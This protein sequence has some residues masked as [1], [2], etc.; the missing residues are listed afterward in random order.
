LGQWSDRLDAYMAEKGLSKRQLSAELAVPYSTVQKWWH[1]QPSRE[2]ITTIRRFLK[3]DAAAT[4]SIFDDK[5]APSPPSV[6]NVQEDSVS[7]RKE[8]NPPLTEQEAERLLS[9]HEIVRDPV[10]HDIWIT[11][12]ERVM[13]DAPAFQR[14]RSLNQLG[15]T[16]LVYPGA[17]HNRFLHS[18][19]TLHCAEQ[20][21]QIVNRN[22]R[23]Y[24]QPSLLD[25]GPYPHLLIRC[26]ALLH[27][28]AHMPFGHTLENEGNLAKGEWHDQGRAKLWLGDDSEW[29]IAGKVREFLR[30]SGIGASKADRVVQD[31]RRY[32]LPG[33][34]DEHP[35]FPV[36]D[37]PSDLDYPFVVD[38]VGNTLCADLL[39]Y[40][41]RDMYF[42]GLRE[43]SGDRVVQ[44]LAIV[45]VVRKPNG[46]GAEEEFQPSEKPDTGK[47]RVVLLAYRFEREHFASGNLK[48][49]PKAEILSEAIDLLRRRFALAEKVYFHRTKI[50]ASAMLISAVGSASTPLTALHTAS[51]ME[52]LAAL[53][54]DSE[55][56]ARH[57][58]A[59]YEARRLYKPVYRLNYREAREEDRQSIRLWQVMYPRYRD[60]K[61]RREREIELESIR[62]IPPGSIAVYCPDNTMNLKQF[63]MLVQSHP[64]ADVKYLKNILDPN[65]KE[66]MET[67]NAR[68]TQLWKLQVFVDPDAVDVSLVANDAVRD[69]SALCESVMGFPNEVPELQRK[70]RHL[71]DQV[72][73]I[74]VREWEGDDR[75]AVPYQVFK[76]LVAA[77]Y[78]G[79][80][81][82]L[83]DS[84]RKRLKAL[85]Q[86]RTS[87]ATDEKA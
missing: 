51:D 39:D 69:L 83:I 53:A 19:G 12:M 23:V 65:R 60:P 71:E 25:I 72:A 81:S 80:G 24:A 67:I 1:R 56:R 49:V 31:I 82:E 45:R 26:C 55:E 74:V 79:S 77:S 44:Y 70:G 66:E 27:D 78:R 5:P 8:P 38:I 48:P 4:Q 41:E 62:R 20:L 63:E 9:Q 17:L 35:D 29:S 61:W 37:Y 30:A 59:A 73:D 76:E 87:K 6:Q 85:M 18:I 10:H 13:M 33:D 50:A 75:G 28:L 16:Q 46:L 40:V 47:G 15:P 7:D 36:K 68:F 57:L 52:F 86:S 2:H 22:F 54:K 34:N 84:Y 14:L 43:K 42:C 11:A 58:I 3:Q 64:G 32:V 21:V